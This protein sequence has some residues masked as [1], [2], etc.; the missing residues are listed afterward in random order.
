[1]EA[2][3]HHMEVYMDDFLAT[4][5][6]SKIAQLHHFSRAILHAIHDMFLPP[7]NNTSNMPNPI[8]ITKLQE[9][10]ICW[11]PVKEMLGWQ[12]NGIT[13]TVLSITN[14]KSDKLKHKLMHHINVKVIE[15]LHGSLQHLAQALPLGKPTLS[16]LSRQLHVWLSCN[17][18]WVHLLENIKQLLRDWIAFIK[19]Q[20]AQPLNVL[21]LIPQEPTT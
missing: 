12:F 18:H 8:S 7:S 15:E 6:L 1:M 3:L 10:G 2:P 13:R 9:E 11:S 17:Q 19:L 14:C 20:Q 5:Q 16:M 4:A 21:Q